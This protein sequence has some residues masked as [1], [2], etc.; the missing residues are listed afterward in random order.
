MGNKNITPLNEF[1]EQN[2]D[3]LIKSNPGRFGKGK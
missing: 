1:M 2:G 3:T